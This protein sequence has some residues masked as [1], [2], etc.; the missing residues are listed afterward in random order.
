[1]EGLFLTDCGQVLINLCDN[2]IKFARA[3]TGEVRLRVSFTKRRKTRIL[4]GHEEV[5]CDVQQADTGET[6]D[7]ATEAGQAAAGTQ[8]SRGEVVKTLTFEVFDNG[9]GMVIYPRVKQNCLQL[10]DMCEA[11]TFTSV[12]LR[13]GALRVEQLALV[14]LACVG[15]LSD[16]KTWSCWW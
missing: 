9:I 4:E 3:G 1:M 13:M 11:E 14:A 16:G 6:S 7:V 5:P 2:A 12:Q 10:L 8:G 15:S